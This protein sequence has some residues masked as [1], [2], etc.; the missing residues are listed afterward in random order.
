[1]GSIPSTERKRRQKE[2]RKEG[3]KEG[4]KRKKEEKERKNYN[5]IM[6]KKCRPV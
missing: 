2:E 6:E 3:K 1:M 5:T 4:R